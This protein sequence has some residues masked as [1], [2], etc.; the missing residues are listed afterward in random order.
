MQNDAEYVVHIGD[1]IDAGPPKT[2]NAMRGSRGRGLQ[3]R[4]S[5]VLKALFC[6]YDKNTTLI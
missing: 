6:T 4:G 2:R 5:R 3:L 1:L